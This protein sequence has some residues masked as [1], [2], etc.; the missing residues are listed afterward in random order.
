MEK[1]NI[2]ILGAGFGGLHFA[3]LIAKKLR[4]RHLLDT[5]S[6]TLI[7]RSDCHLFTPLLY[8]IAADPDHTPECTYDTTSLIKDLPI[9]FKEGVVS[10]LDL[11]NGDIHL[12]TGE[13]I[14]A[15]FLVIAL[16]SETNYFGI[17]GLK[18]HSLQLKGAGDAQAI[19]EALTKLFS[20]SGDK[21]IVVGGAGANGIELAA[22][23]KLWADRAHRENDALNAS[24]SIV[25]AMPSVFPGLDPRVAAIA[26]KRLTM[27]GVNV[28]TNMKIVGVSANEISLD[29]GKKQPFDL[30]V[31][32]GGIKTPDML[33]QLPLEKEPRGKPVAKSDMACLPATP[34]LKLYPMVYGLGDS[35]CFMDPKTNRPVPAV[36][37]AA[38]LQ[39]NVAAN[40]LLEEIKK[41]EQTGY[42]PKLKHYVPSDYPYVIPI[43]ANWAVAKIGSV[44]FSGWPAWAFAKLIEIHYLVSIMSFGEAI[45]AWG[46][47]G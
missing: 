15:E 25:E 21:K 36:V 47:M 20:E 23:I 37:R 38:V 13:E 35:V 24:V 7:D 45:K 4:A 32:T 3:M 2:V 6:I 17:S 9:T 26:T 34:D 43:G 29:G 11:M 12:K 19:R 22:E 40:N 5:Y 16:G 41:S 8:K 46:K 31:W 39:A 18:E 14:K 28:M 27:L 42:I 44:V 1:K 30:F 10:A 33:T